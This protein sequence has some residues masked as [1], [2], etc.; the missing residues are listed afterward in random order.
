MN[1]QRAVSLI[2]FLIPPTVALVVSMYL[3]S[4]FLFPPKEQPVNFF[5]DSPPPPSVNPNISSERIKLN[6]WLDLDFTKDASLFDELAQEFEQA[7]P[8]IDVRLSSFVRES[9]ARRV[10]HAVSTGDSPD[11]VQGHVY[12]L[13]GQG[14]VEP[15]DQ[16]VE[17]WNPR[18]RNEFLP[19]AWREAMWQNNLYGIPVD[20]YTVVLFYNRVHF[21]EAKLPYPSANNSLYDIL[22]A[23]QTLT[24][25]QKKRYG[26]GLTTDPWY[27]YT[28]LT[29]AGSEV[30]NG[31]PEAGFNLTLNT[32]SNVEVVNFLQDMVDKG[33]SPLPSSRPR[34][35]EEA[36]DLFLQQKLSI[37][38]GE[39]QDIHFMQIHDSK[40]PLGVTT[41]PRTLAGNSATSVL[42]TTALFIPRGSPH[43]DAAFEFIKWASDER[44][45]RHMARR[46]GRYPARTWLYTSPEVTKNPLLTP[47][48][49]HLD[50]AHA[51]RLDLFL[52]AEDAFV[53]ALR[54]SFYHLE[55]PSTAL[56]RAQIIGQFSM[57]E[58]LQW[59]PK[60]KK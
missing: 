56:R 48:F 22:K 20:V 27:F 40:F 43:A 24:D 17:A 25:P 26:V 59:T 18:L 41:L 50:D 7:Y 23:A 8:Q 16:R 35:Y 11:V 6:V 21:D 30:V 15:L 19:V 57:K 34:D 47:F 53:D 5:V 36:R 32:Q 52:D 38:F 49:E 55:E 29:A 39:T 14:L 31:N 46:L 3:F 10:R 44:Y 4:S 54:L 42:G 12:A 28:W 2:Y 1:Q 9:M 60:S 45:V 51:Y 37:Y 13:A 58:A 33:Y